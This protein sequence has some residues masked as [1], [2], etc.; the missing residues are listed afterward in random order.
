MKFKEFLQ[1]RDSCEQNENSKAFEFMD[2]IE[3]HKEKLLRTL[4][5]I[6]QKSTGARIRITDKSSIWDVQFETNG[7]ARGMKPQIFKEL[8]IKGYGNPN[9]Y[10]EELFLEVEYEGTLINGKKVRVHIGDA[11]FDKEANLIKTDI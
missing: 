6:L 4:T 3:A 11:T 1:S 8:I 5:V 10:G 7:L 9:K 2:S